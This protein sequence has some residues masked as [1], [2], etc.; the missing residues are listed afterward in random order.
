MAIARVHIN[1]AHALPELSLSLGLFIMSLVLT[2]LKDPETGAIA[3]NGSV[4]VPPAVVERAILGCQAFFFLYFAWTTLR[5]FNHLTMSLALPHADE[6][7]AR[8]D[9]S[10]LLDWNAYFAFVAG[11]PFL[12]WTLD[13]AYASLSYAI[14]IV[15]FLLLV[16]L[17]RIRQTEFFAVTFFATAIICTSIGMFFPAEAAVPICLNARNFWTNFR[18]RRASIISTTCAHC[19]AAIR[20]G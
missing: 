6:W 1:V 3:R 13:Q 9:R 4:L 14:A 15:I 20:S 16:V 5:I 10:L 17:G 18:H 19:A 12:S 7:L 11:K 2:R 8:A